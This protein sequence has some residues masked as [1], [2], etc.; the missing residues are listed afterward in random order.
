MALNDDALFTAAVGYVYVG[1]V[2]TTK[3]TP[4]QI[5]NFDPEVGLTGAWVDLGHT[6]REDLPEFGY[7]GGTTETRGTW[8]AVALREVV[9]DPAVDYVNIN[10]HQFDEQGLS[11][12]YGVTNSSAVEGEFE[13]ADSST[14]S[15]ERAVCIVM[16]DGDIQIAFYARK[17]GI[18][19]N[20]SIS[21]GVDEFSVL[22]I[23]ATFLKDGNNSLM[24]WISQD[25]GISGESS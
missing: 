25:T 21:M 22:P 14:S 13:I 19:R 5:S 2:G 15:T 4:T 8:R 11:L 7:E 1:P 12:Y 17:A 16:I 6:S 3:P 23:R 10:L 9:T 20:A 24:S 18:R